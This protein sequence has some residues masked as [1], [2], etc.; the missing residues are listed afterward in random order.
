M[1]TCKWLTGLEE[2]ETGCT[3]LLPEPG[4]NEIERK[5]MKRRKERRGVM[6]K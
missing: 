2:R 4:E 3:A 1:I 5:G 6:G